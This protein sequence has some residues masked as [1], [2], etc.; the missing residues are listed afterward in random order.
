VSTGKTKG[1]LTVLTEPSMGSFN[2][3]V[4][5]ISLEERAQEL[6][7]MYGVCE[8]AFI[9][10]EVYKLSYGQ[11]AKLLGTTYGA[12]AVCVHKI[13]SR[14]QA[15]K[16][17]D[18]PVAGSPGPEDFREA[19]KGN[20]L[21]LECQML[22]AEAFVFA[23]AKE[24]L[25]ASAFWDVF[26]YAKAAHRVVFPD[27]Y[28][29]LFSQAGMDYGKL[30]RLFRAVKVKER[31]YVGDGIVAYAFN[32]IDKST[33]FRGYSNPRLTFNLLTT[34]ERL[35]RKNPT[36]EPLVY[37]AMVVSD[38]LIYLINTKRV[39]IMQTMKE[40]YA[41]ITRMYDLD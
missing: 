39:E 23:V 13:R 32:L 7:R 33:F 40:V 20:P 34:I 12:V 29:Y 10:R 26:I 18:I 25:P 36:K 8:A 19:C 28:N 5:N 9:L 30:R 31:W 27:I 16:L 21:N 11:I 15:E 24:A 4:L 17:I 2:E 22:E 41:T 35:A 14:R 38:K 6:R 37:L 3:E 1:S